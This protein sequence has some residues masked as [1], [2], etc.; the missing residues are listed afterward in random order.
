MDTLLDYGIPRCDIPYPNTKWRTI[1]ELL[2]ALATSPNEEQRAKFGGAITCFLHPLNFNANDE[3]SQKLIVDF[4][5]YLKYDGYEIVLNDDGDGYKLVAT[6]EK[7]K[8][9]LPPTPEKKKEERI[10][11]TSIEPITEEIK[12]AVSEALV[13]ITSG[14]TK[15]EKY[16]ERVEEETSRLKQ[17]EV[18]ERLAVVREAYK[19]LMAIT[20]SFCIDPTTPSREL[21]TAYVE[22]SQLVSKALSGF[23]GDTSDFEVFSFGEY[24]ENNFG[25]PFGSLYRAELEFKS[26]GKKMHWDEIRPEMNAVLG[27]IE[28]V[29][30]AANAPEIL[31]EP[32][33]QTT[34]NSARLLLSQTAAER[35]E[36]APKDA[37]QKMQMEITS[38]PELQLRNAEDTTITKGKKRIQLPK[39]KPTDWAKISIRFIDE[40]NVL[41]IA[42]KK[43]QVSA[44]YEALGFSNDTRD[45]PNKAWAFLLGLAKNNGATEEL[46]TPI[47]DKIKQLK[48]QLSDRLKVIFKNDTEPFF[49]PSDDHIYTIKINLVPPVAKDADTDTFGTRE[50][51]EETMTLM[52]DE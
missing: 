13:E 23:C 10:S 6:G 8:I 16:S 32:K 26:K 22:L 43:E 31:S 44:D 21:N 29:C 52:S 36:A 48:K 12:A 24:A 7:T 33:I 51:L 47:P 11:F 20:S 45:K 38:I 5:K 2:L 1:Q 39:F 17:P 25:I 28:E 14:T 4:N 34:I 42:D 41:I 37:V 9:K 35:K 3:E 27:K 50:Y 18:A 49:D 30:D 15:E 40:R 46:P 19:T